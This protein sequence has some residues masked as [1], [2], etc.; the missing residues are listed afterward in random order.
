MAL[1]LFAKQSPGLREVLAELSAGSTGGKRFADSRRRIQ[2]GNTSF[3][4][5][6]TA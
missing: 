2:P 6:R 1:P 3:R 5:L 4:N